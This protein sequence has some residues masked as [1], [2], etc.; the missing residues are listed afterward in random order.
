MGA[1]HPHVASK[2]LGQKE[3]Q[4]PETGGHE[5]VQA[6]PGKPTGD[7]RA[8]RLAGGPQHICYSTSHGLPHQPDEVGTIIVPIFIV[9][10][11][12]N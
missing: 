5:H 10:T 7:K 2:F 12:Q 9:E 8:K 11:Q 1:E 6:P 3:L 4:V